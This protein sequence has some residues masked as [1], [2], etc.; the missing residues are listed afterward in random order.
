MRFC[1]DVMFHNIETDQQILQRFKVAA[2]E[3]P[4]QERELPS[5]KLQT[6]AP[7]HLGV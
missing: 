3:N 2:V 1:M 4:I 7:P 5:G 6:D